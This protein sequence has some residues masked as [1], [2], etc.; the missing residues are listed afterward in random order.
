VCGPVEAGNVVEGRLMDI[1]GNTPKFHLNP[2]TH[3]ILLRHTIWPPLAITLPSANPSMRTLSP[4]P[5]L[6][7][8]KP[9]QAHPRLLQECSS[10]RLK[11][12][13]PRSTPPSRLFKSLDESPQQE[14]WRLLMPCCWQNC[15]RH[16]RNYGEHSVPCVEAG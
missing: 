1:Y 14:Q 9:Q 12:N 16:S 11:G 4:N 5:L 3:L 8:P 2:F 13:L 10:D 15:E 7:A 6:S